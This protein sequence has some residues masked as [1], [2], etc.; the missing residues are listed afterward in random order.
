MVATFVA[1][2][3]VTSSFSLLVAMPQ[4]LLVAIPFAGVLILETLDG[5]DFD[6]KIARNMPL[7]NA[8]AA[9]LVF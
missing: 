9:R 4:E 1:M 7:S 6:A 2:H 5:R 8:S 3:L